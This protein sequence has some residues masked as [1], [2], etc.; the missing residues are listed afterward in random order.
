MKIYSVKENRPI[1]SGVRYLVWL[2]GEDEVQLAEYDVEN[3]EGYRWEIDG[4][5]GDFDD[6]VIHYARIPKRPR[7]GKS[8][9][10]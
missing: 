9:S 1:M 10:V 6:E 5:R 2:R 3:Q 4:Y 7:V 8:A